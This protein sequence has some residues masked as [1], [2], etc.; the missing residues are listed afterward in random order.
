MKFNRNNIIQFMINEIRADMIKY[1][2]DI[3][4]MIMIFYLIF[5]NL[6][7]KVCLCDTIEEFVEKYMEFYEEKQLYIKPFN[8][9]ELLK[10]IFKILE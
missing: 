5:Q 2:I 9:L 4:G 6:K 1:N 8:F 10:E 3:L 7:L